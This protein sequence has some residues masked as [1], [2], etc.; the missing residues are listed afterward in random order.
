[1]IHTCRAIERA[2]MQLK[3]YIGNNQKALGIIKGERHENY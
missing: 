3:G 2:A 1:M